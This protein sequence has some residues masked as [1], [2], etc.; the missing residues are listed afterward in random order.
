MSRAT[1]GLLGILFFACGPAA[2]AALDAPLGDSPAAATST[3]AAATGASV[4]LPRLQASGHY[5]YFLSFEAVVRAADLMVAAEVVSVQPGRRVADHTGT[6]FLP[7]TNVGLRVT[8][9]A[10]GAAPAGVTLTFEQTGG[11]YRP[12]R[13][14]ADSR[15][16]E[17]PL[18]PDAPAGMRPLPPAPVPD[19]DVLYELREDPL[20]NVGDRV[21]L[22]LVWKP[23]LG[24]FQLVNPQGRFTV[25]AKGKVHTLLHSDPAVGKLDG[26]PKYAL[27]ELAARVR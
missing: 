1:L 21:V 7:F 10:K 19:R 14:I 2:P 16:Q 8:D 13:A 6:D 18:P 17:A 24:L 12:T 15:G 27:L 3:T 23:G 4:N 22:A 20:L 5:N 25:D 11:V 9:V 26:L